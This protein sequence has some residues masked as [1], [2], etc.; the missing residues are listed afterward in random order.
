M[1]ADGGYGK[2]P[3]F[4]WGLEAMGEI[5]GVDIHNDQQ[6]YLEYPRPAIP[7][8]FPARGRPRSRR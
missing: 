4:L 8:A 1:G 5:F 3:A 6:L 2:E 7:E